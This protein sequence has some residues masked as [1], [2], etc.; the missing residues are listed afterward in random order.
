MATIT[1][2]YAIDSTVYHV[3]EYLGVRKGIIRKITATVMP[4]GGSPAVVYVV[5]FADARDGIIDALEPTLFDDVD[6]ALAYY[7]TTYVI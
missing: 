7:K 1:Y 4:G 6:L 5:A 2:S 3:D